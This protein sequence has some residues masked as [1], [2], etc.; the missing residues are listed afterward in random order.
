MSHHRHGY[1]PLGTAKAKDPVERLSLARVLP[2]ANLSR[3]AEVIANSSVLCAELSEHI[4][5]V[6]EFPRTPTGK[7]DL[8]K[9]GLNRNHAVG[10]H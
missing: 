6:D 1:S 9:L 2:A 3:L 4:E 7:P 5:F 10:G 8:D